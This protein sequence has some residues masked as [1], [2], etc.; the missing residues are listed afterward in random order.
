MRAVFLQGG[1]NITSFD[2][3]ISTFFTFYFFSSNLT[4]CLHS[5]LFTLTGF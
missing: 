3:M 1:T 2:S 5:I 4:S